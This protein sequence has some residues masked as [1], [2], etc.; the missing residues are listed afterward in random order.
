MIET[1]NHFPVSSA[2]AMPTV[3]AAEMAQVDELRNMRGAGLDPALVDT[4][5]EFRALPDRPPDR[6]FDA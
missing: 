6:V 5:V 4:F 3:S 2:S 1:L